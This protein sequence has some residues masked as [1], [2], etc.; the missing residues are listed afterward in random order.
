[1]TKR[2]TAVKFIALIV[3]A[4]TL[5]NTAALFGCKKEEEIASEVTRSVTEETAPEIEPQV[6]RRVTNVYRSDLLNLPPEHIFGGRMYYSDGRLYMLCTDFN[7]SRDV[8][9]SFDTNG[10]NPQS[11]PIDET[12]GFN[13]LRSPDGSLVFMAFSYDQ[14]TQTN[15][16]QLIKTAP[17]GSVVF[18]IDPEPML[19]DSG[20]GTGTDTKYPFNFYYSMSLAALDGEGNIYLGYQIPGSSVLV[21]LSPDGKKL[22]DIPF[23]GFLSDIITGS[24]GRVFVTYS[25]T[26]SSDIIMGSDN[27]VFVTYNETGSAETEI[28]IRYVDIQKKALGEKLEIP[29]TGENLINSKIYIGGGYDLYIK[30]DTGLY[31]VNRSETEPVLLVDWLD[32]DVAFGWVP[33]LIVIDSDKFVYKGQ[34]QLTGRPQIVFLTRVPD[35]E[36]TQKFE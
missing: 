12:S 17:D 24:D 13:F 16:C 35:D 15:S 7:I 11:V 3:C 19:P 6:A 5:L 22:F 20:T 23:T 21:C 18:T 29:D 2:K 34:D 26:G 10:L 25:E 32:S 27:R 8:W 28:E 36:V 4:V 1:M 31:G 33:S 14:S 30:N 9:Y